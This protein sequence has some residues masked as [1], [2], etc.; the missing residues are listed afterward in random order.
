MSVKSAFAALDSE[1]FDLLVSDI[2][3]P[4]GSGLD[5]M[6]HGR[7]HLGLK[8]IALSGYGTDQDARASKE[9]GFAHHTD[10]AVGPRRPGRPDQADGV[11]MPGTPPIECDAV[12]LG[13][14]CR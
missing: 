4:D 8:G 7:D 12:R 5:I 10:Q 11:V 6:R 1:R 13:T 14:P 9:A 3:L 2:G